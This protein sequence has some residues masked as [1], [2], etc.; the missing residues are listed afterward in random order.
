METI[1]VE[2]SFPQPED[3]A[4]V[5]AAEA[6]VAWCLAQ[7]DVTFLYAYVARDHRRRVCVYHAPDAEAVR[8]TQHTA[9]LPFDR[10]WPATR[11]VA[12]ALPTGACFVVERTVA[13]PMTRA[14][15][16]AAMAGAAPCFARR[17]AT[18][19]VSHVAHDG[20]R[21]VCVFTA[22]DAETVRIVNRQSG[23]PCDQ[24]WPAY[25]LVP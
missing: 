16:E 18:L 6:A 19:A 5:Q 22:P 1:V 10:V 25:P 24:V 8:V 23:L 3:P 17:A 7:H 13:R 4:Q 21:M 12:G 20:T 11:L 15:I 2:R 14:E 9:R